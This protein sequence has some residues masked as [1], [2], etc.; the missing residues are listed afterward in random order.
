MPNSKRAD[1]RLAQCQLC[2]VVASRPAFPH[3]QIPAGGRNAN[4]DVGCVRYLPCLFLVDCIWRGIVTADPSRDRTGPAFTAGCSHREEIAS[5]VCQKQGAASRR[6]NRASADGRCNEKGFV[7]Q[8]DCTDEAGCLSRGREKRSRPGTSSRKLAAL[9]S[10]S[11]TRTEEL[12]PSQT[13][14][15]KRRHRR[16]GPRMRTGPARWRRSSPA[17]RGRLAEARARPAQRLS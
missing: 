17:S 14:G 6:V 11:E 9:R 15:A 5:S 13:R 12:M 8:K 3:G 4:L 10:H 7:R 1:G 16:Q 2:R